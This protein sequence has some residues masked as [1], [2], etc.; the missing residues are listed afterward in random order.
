MYRLLKND[1]IAI[2]DQRNYDAILDNG[3]SSKHQSYYLGETVDVKPEELTEDVSRC[4]TNTATGRS[5]F[6]PCAPSVRTT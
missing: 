5:I 6:S 2:I 1:G 3:F 4:G